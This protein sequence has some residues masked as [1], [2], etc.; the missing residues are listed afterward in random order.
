MSNYLI[1]HGIPG[2]KWGVRRFQ[3][4]KGN[5]NSKRQSKPKK[6]MSNKKKVAIGV[7]VV[8]GILLVSGIIAVATINSKDE[9]DYYR[10]SGDRKIKAADNLASKVSLYE[11]LGDSYKNLANSNK[12]NREL[13]NYYYNKG[14]TWTDNYIWNNTQMNSLYNSAEDDY[15]QANRT[16]YGMYKKIIK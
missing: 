10:R 11:Q 4:N 16:M 15:R 7:A 5:G 1:H 13:S 2:M 12:S 6:K 14:R 8:A 9:Y 3:P